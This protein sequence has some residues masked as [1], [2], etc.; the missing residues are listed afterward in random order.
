M[1][2][3][4][5]H[6]PA[7]DADDP[8]GVTAALGAAAPAHFAALGNSEILHREKPALFCSARCPGDRILQAYDLA[9][10]LRDEGTTVIGGFHSPVEKGSASS[11]SAPAAS[12]RPSANS[13][14]NGQSP[15]PRLNGTRRQTRR[16]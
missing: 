8:V 4:L 9:R 5:K 7:G 3:D 11:M 6:F 10:K 15:S 16:R 13:C 1:K 2:P 14:A 12:S